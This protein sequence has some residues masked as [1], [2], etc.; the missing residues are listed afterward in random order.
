MSIC[1]EVDELLS[2]SSFVFATPDGASL[3]VV[4]A[5]ETPD[6]D[7][8]D[9]LRVTGVVRRFRYDAYAEEF[10]L[11]QR[12]RYAPFAGEPVL[13]AKSVNENHSPE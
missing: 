8:G 10:E 1:S 6:I 13:V 9:Q 7:E 5:L 2:P 4:S 12:R 11:G 3:L